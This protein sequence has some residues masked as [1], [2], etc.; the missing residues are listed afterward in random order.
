[1]SVLLQE[2]QQPLSND[3]M[4][5]IERSSSFRLPSIEENH[6]VNVVTL[7]FPRIRIPGSTKVFLEENIL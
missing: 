5:T 4:K 2:P 7:D 1:M 3:S 6:L